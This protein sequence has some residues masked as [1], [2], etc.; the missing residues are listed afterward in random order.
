[1]NQSQKI[2][3]L[4]I[5]FANM[6]CNGGVYNGRRYISE[7]SFD[8]MTSPKLD[9]IAMKGWSGTYFCC[10]VKNKLTILYFTQICHASTT[11]QAV[12][13]DKAVYDIII[14]K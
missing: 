2:F 5:S 13:I 1:M 4:P 8:Y 11:P 12:E 9:A 14:R 7:K 6:L 3:V 10:D